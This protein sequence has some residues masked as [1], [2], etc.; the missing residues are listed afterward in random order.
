MILS[1]EASETEIDEAN[2]HTASFIAERGGSTVN[3]DT[4]GLRRLA[5]PI[6]KFTEGNYEVTRFTLGP[7][8][9]EEL[10]RTL[11]MSEQVLRHLIVKV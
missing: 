9:T 4:W 2:Q 1:P 10:G 6:K 3:T 11:E 7:E 5:Y 8:A